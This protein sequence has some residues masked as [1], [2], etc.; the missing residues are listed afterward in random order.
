M[1]LNYNT[2]WGIEVDANS[3]NAVRLKKSK[4]GVAIT[5]FHVFPYAEPSE[6]DED[7]VNNTRHGLMSLFG[8]GVI[9]PGHNV[10]VSVPGRN[11]FSRTVELPPMDMAKSH[12]LVKYEASQQIPHPLEEVVWDYHLDKQDDTVSAIL[13]AAHREYVDK[14]TE[15]FT[16][17]KLNIVGI[18]SSTLAVLNYFR[19]DVDFDRSAVLMDVKSK[20]ID[21]V[22][23]D[24][25]RFW[26]RNIARG[27][28]DINKA[29]MTK[30]KIPYEKAEELKRNGKQPEK[31]AQ[32]VQPVFKAM[33][34]EIQRSIGHY[35]SQHDDAQLQD[36]FLIGNAFRMRP[37]AEHFQANLRLKLH[38]QAKL[39]RLAESV[40]TDLEVFNMNHGDMV[41]PLG[42]ALQGI[43]ETTITIN[44][45]PKEIIEARIAKKRSIWLVASAVL[46]L[47]AGILHF[48]SVGSAA[49]DM[50]KLVKGSKSKPSPSKIN[51]EIN[52]RDKEIQA[53]LGVPNQA[54]AK[55]EK[56]QQ[57]LYD[58]E[59]LFHRNEYL[60][61][62]NE[63]N[64]VLYQPNVTPEEKVYFQNVNI[65]K[66]VPKNNKK[67]QLKASDKHFGTPVDD[68]APKVYKITAK[69]TFKAVNPNLAHHE[70][71]YTFIFENLVKKL[72]THG[73]FRDFER[74]S[75]AL[76]VH[77]DTRVI[78]CKFD[79]VGYYVA[80][81]EG[82]E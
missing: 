65:S 78:I 76:G 69:G 14:I 49:D 38:V 18:Q 60:R 58:R 3:F 39:G 15:V 29:L 52:K 35:V 53:Q 79:I 22:I 30:F 23:N 12:E 75:I 48:N 7:L 2:V 16:E 46:F 68:R 37:L 62:L 19:Y 40:E 28:D 61:A 31:I 1:T 51:S 11:I 9:K 34:N 77:D 32:V 50:A 43:G 55:L 17:A 67:Y 5:H 57:N 6:T 82:E 13:F 45:I 10:V 54:K 21:F 71:N 70:D 73:H 27:G 66:D 41:V 72:N 64:K 25:V 26:Q 8:E 42:L 81:E 80:P 63:F 24:G 33:T 36:G 74:D 56:W 47:L 59:T 44:L 4:D 20:N